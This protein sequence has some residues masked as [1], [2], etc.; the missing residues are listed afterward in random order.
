MA[1]GSDEHNAGVGEYD[2]LR[3]ILASASPHACD[4]ISEVLAKQREL[5]ELLKLDPSR[6]ASVCSTCSGCQRPCFSVSSC[7]G[8][9]TV[10]R[11]VKR[12]AATSCTKCPNVVT[13]NC[14]K[15]CCRECG[16]PCVR[17]KSLMH[18]D[19]WQNTTYQSSQPDHD[20]A[21]LCE[22]CGYIVARCS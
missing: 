22:H 7:A 9:S 16:I 12:C 17:C 10:G 15:G 14:L 21:P 3:E 19:C 5:A 8:R 11:W 6:V 2:I 18:K 20:H 13:Y 1:A 4:K